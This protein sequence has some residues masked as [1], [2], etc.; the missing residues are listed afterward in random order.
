MPMEYRGGT[1][2]RDS[3]VLKS[4]CV[5][6]AATRL[7]LGGCVICPG[8]LTARIE[9]FDIPG[10]KEEANSEQDGKQAC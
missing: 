2:R 7:V 1:Q 4:D 9:H 3:Q 8:D 6:I 10:P 5:K